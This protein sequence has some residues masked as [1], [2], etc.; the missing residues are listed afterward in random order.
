METAVLMASF[1]ARNSLSEAESLTHKHDNANE[2][3]IGIADQTTV[4]DLVGKSNPVI[5]VLHPRA[6][7][8]CIKHRKPR[9]TSL[10]P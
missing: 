8:L 5:G 7:E 3:L 2:M 9:P 4:G 1:P 6:T 10:L